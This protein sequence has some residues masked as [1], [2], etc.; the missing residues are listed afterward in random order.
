MT[1]SEKEEKVRG[2][3]KVA[4]W[5][6]K[7]SIERMLEAKHTVMAAYRAH[8]KEVDIEY[9]QFRRY[10]NELIRSKDENQGKKPGSTSVEPRNKK[11]VIRTRVPGQ[12]AFVSSDTPR[13]NLIKPKE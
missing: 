9:Q 4:F 2:A 10:V 5:A 1:K 6:H 11:A 7:D 13:E 8:K 12:P 3:G